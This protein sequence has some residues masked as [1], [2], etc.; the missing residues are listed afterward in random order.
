MNAS[1][2]LDVVERLHARLSAVKTRQVSS[3]GERQNIRSVVG[4]WFSEYRTSFVEIVGEDQYILSMDEKM[5]S[6]LKL[7]SGQNARRTV[8]RSVG[9]TV[10]HFKN[11]LLVPLSRAYWSRAPQRSPA[12]RDEEAATRLRQLNADLGD[13]YEQAVVDIEDFQRISYRGPAAELREVLTTVLHILAPTGQVEATEWYREA[14]RLGTR[15]EHTPTRAER[16]K[17][18]LRS[19]LKGSAV[20]DAAES[21][22]SS[23]EERLANVINATY[24]RGSAATHGGTERDELVQLLPYI[25]A[26]LR[27]LLPPLSAVSRSVSPLLLERRKPWYFIKGAD[28]RGYFVAFVNARGSCSMRKWEAETGRYVSKVYRSGKY[29][30]NFQEVIRGATELHVGQQ[31]NLERDCRIRLP[32]AVLAELKTQLN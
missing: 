11:N 18:I 31:P 3:L 17:F 20:T 2:F 1:E 19:R 4:A 28:G 21:Y 13:S 8:V 23:V 26:L 22:M 9:S 10:Q 29:Q 6:L 7:A 30:D 5:Q 16:T 12:G 25:N 15:T 32:E 27:E 14:R 24:R